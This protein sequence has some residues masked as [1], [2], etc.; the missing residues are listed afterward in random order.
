MF[1]DLLISE[2]VFMFSVGEPSAG[3]DTLTKVKVGK[4]KKREG[5]VQKKQD[6]GLLCSAPLPLIPRKQ[7]KEGCMRKMR[8]EHF[9]GNRKTEKG[10]VVIGSHLQ[11]LSIQKPSAAI[12]ENTHR[13]SVSREESYK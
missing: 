8:C 2:H 7:R 3:V 5:R 9:S 11:L 13:Y 4:K 10:K 6:G 1:F 12:W